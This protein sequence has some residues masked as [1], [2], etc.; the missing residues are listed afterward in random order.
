M[1][2]IV[3]LRLKTGLKQEKPSRNKPHFLIKT[4]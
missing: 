1:S 2:R 3:Q 4:G